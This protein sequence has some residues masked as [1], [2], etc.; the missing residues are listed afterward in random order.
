MCDTVCPHKDKCTSHP[1]N[2]G[3]CSRNT[4]KRDYYK[5]RRRDWYTPYYPWYPDTTPYVQPYPWW[6]YTITCGD[7]HTTD[8]SWEITTI[9]WN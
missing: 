2:C 5:P 8:N 1:H 9:T 7:N 3:S 4:G 6:Q